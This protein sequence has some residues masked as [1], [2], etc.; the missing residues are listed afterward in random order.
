M[1][2]VNT[3]RIQKVR[4]GLLQ[5]LT[6]EKGKRWLEGAGWLAAGFLLSAGALGRDFQ[7]LALGLLCAAPPG[8][9]AVLLALGGAIGYP[10]F[11][12][13]PGW[14]GSAWM[15]FGLMV[16]LGLGDRGIVKRQR[17]LLPALSALIVAGTGVIWLFRFGDDTTIPMY[18]LRVAVGV[19]TA[20]VFSLWRQERNPWLDWAVE[21][22]GVL[23]LA[24]VVPVRY[25][26][27]GFIAAGYLAAGGSLPAAVLAGLSLDLAQV[28]NV[29]MTAV[30]CVASL[31]G[32]L[33]KGP[34]WLPVL[35]GAVSFL[36]VAALS[37]VWDVR[38]LPGLILGGALAGLF[39]MPEREA[40]PRRHSGEAMVAQ[41][42]LEQ[43]A[44]ALRQMEQA[45]LLTPEPELDKGAVLAKS[46][47]QACDTCPER[48]SCKGR[49]LLPAMPESV[50]EQ[51]GL[52]EEDLPTGCRKPNRLLSELRR[53]QE[54]LRR[55][56]G[57][58]NRLLAYRGA[59]REQYGFLADF[60]E[61]L[62]D[63]LAQ[64]HDYREPRFRPEIGLS[65]RSSEA[66]NGDKCVWFEGTGNSFYVLLCDGMG[67]GAEAARE[68][69]EAAGLL[70]QMLQAGFPAEYALRC[71]NSLQI[72]REMGGCAT[73]DLVKLQLDTG[74]GTVYKWGAAP[75]YLMGG[76]QLRKIGTASP[77]PGLSGSAREMVDRL[78]LGRGERLILLSDGVSEAGLLD[79]A[80]TTPT[81]LPGEMAAAIL[82]K[83]RSGG[84]DATAVVIRLIPGRLS[85]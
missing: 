3:Q 74:K 25:L 83:E 84:D 31:L 53:G 59:S 18:L 60:L 13:T 68:S 69:E 48:R 71:L 21:A 82:E 29:K 28:T 54:Q 78:S 77:P 80:R 35:S 36:P 58:G 34:K 2:M 45:L 76:G 7:P 37:G 73:V 22:I 11:W 57:D 6:G 16:A 5:A 79:S 42:R 27:L 17:T 66:V 63:E 23:A 24:Q 49:S 4:D 43:M 47:A 32:R 19:L 56:K 67:T 62:S 33:P 46:C 61:N 55:M 50:L 26:G 8:W 9:R 72:L 41:V 39:P 85:A 51:P 40:K 12:G 64:R 65:T 14:Q 70:K 44:L 10:V 38:P 81:Q 15:G 1:Q 20:G 30:M 52:S 75:S